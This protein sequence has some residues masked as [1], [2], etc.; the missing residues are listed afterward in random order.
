MSLSTAT[1]MFKP[2]E[3]KAALT[4]VGADEPAGP[5]AIPA[6][7][8][9]CGVRRGDR[10]AGVAVLILE[11][12]QPGPAATPVDELDYFGSGQLEAGRWTSGPRSGCW[13]CSASRSSS[14]SSG[15]S[16]RAGR[17]GSGPGSS[18]C[19]HGR[20]SGGAAAGALISLTLAVAGLPVGIWVHE[21][22]VDVG[23]SVQSIGG[24][25]FDRARSAAIAA[26]YAAVGALL[27]LGLQRRW[28]A[29]WWLAAT[30]VVVAFAVASS[31]SRRSS[32]RRSS[33]TSI[34]CP[35]APSAATCSSLADRAEVEI[36]D[37]YRVDAS[38]RRTS[39][40]AYVGG[41][42]LDQEGRDLRQPARRRR[43]GRRCARSSP[44]S[45]LTSSSGTS[46]AACC[47]SR[48]SRRSGCCSSAR[49]ERRS[50]P[51]PVPGR[52]RLRRCRPTRWPC[53]SP[54]S[55]LE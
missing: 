54:L 53:R 19:R 26:L 50:R 6:R 3:A 52:G 55:R 23:I 48:S 2:P 16:S 5:P 38:S 20:C 9:S 39:L 51:V 15:S 34:G 32:S 14:R 33:T 42:R 27:L 1:R 45:S 31:S 41:I 43:A 30:G 18:D 47:S 11:P 37:V 7:P 49:P 8:D 46:G 28:R 24:W 44:T 22:A 12:A 13:G 17:A 40:N 36:G 35:T 21:I 25:L 29:L 4:I 10:G